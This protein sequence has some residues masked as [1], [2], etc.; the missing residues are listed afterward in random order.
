MTRRWEAEIHGAEGAE[1]AAPRA[2]GEPAGPAVGG[3][4]PA[5]PPG[6]Q[7]SGKVGGLDSGRLTRV[8]ILLLGTYGLR[9]VTSPTLHFL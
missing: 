2:Q 5:S 9:P 7:G 1:K 4:L 6:T 3:G 8:R